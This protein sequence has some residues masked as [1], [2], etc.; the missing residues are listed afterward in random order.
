MQSAIDQIG[1]QASSWLDVV[2]PSWEVAILLK[3]AE[4]K[5]EAPS[6]GP[7]QQ[8]TCSYELYPGPVGGALRAG[9]GLVG[10]DLGIIQPPPVVLVTAQVA[11]G[12]RVSRVQTH[13][14]DEVRLRLSRQPVL[15]ATEGEH[16]LVAGGAS[17][18]AMSTTRPAQTHRLSIRL[19]GLLIVPRG[20][21]RC[22]HAGLDEGRVE[23]DRGA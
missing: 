5:N 21:L 7:F 3:G 17:F 14:D 12:G 1:R 22:R 11:P 2:N 10:G 20:L 19:S 8:L 4:K 18:R 13:G 15:F 9:L 23:T 16:H 6:G